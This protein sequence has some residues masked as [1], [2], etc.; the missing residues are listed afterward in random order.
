M[1]GSK[2]LPVDAVLKKTKLLTLT[3]NAKL[4]NRKPFATVVC[5]NQK[6]LR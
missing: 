4:S 6:L 2:I 3:V 5:Y 1:T